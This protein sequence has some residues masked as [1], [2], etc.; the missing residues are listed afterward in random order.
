MSLTGTCKQALRKT[1]L[2][3]FPN[4]DFAKEK[5]VLHF[6]YHKVLTVYF[7]RVMGHLSAE[8]NI[9]FRHCSADLD[10]F[11]HLTKHA[12]ASGIFSIHLPKPVDLDGY[13]PFVGSHFI[14]DP[15]DIVVSGYHFHLWT[16]EPWCI[17]PRFPW[18]RFVSDP[19]FQERI[20]PSIGTLPDES[21]SYQAFLKTLGKR[22]G[23]L[24]EMILRQ[25][26]FAVM[27]TW[28]YEDARILSVKYEDI[29]ADEPKAF[30]RI[31]AHYGLPERLKRRT[32]ELSRAY[33]IKQQKKGAERHT[34]DGRLDQWKN[35][36]EAVHHETFNQMYPGLT[37]KLGYA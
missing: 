28:D 21:T 6:S 8:F 33:A 2:Q 1:R 37:A 10:L 11:D 27:D 18:Q 9:R 32:V 36:F 5:L 31:A 7:G 3:F 15:R 4:R 13:P 16:T 19:C 34:R 29:L 17:R 30:Q 25:P 24:L 20:L 26:T 12:R 23:M 35:E 22:E 14:R